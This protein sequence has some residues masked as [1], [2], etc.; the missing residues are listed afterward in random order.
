VLEI[1]LLV[2][3]GKKLA[4][5]ASSKGRSKGWAALGVAFWLGGEVVG[6]IIATLLGLQGLAAYPV[7]LA[8]A[9]AGIFVAWMV[10]KNLPDLAPAPG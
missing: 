7:A 2:R 8:I 6:F 10:V 5:L 3:F 1:I 9:G 4:E